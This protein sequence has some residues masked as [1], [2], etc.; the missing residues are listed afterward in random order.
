MEDNVIIKKKTN[1]FA[2]FLTVLA[3]I[4]ILFTALILLSS[5]F[6]ILYY[7]VLFCILFLT[8]F[9]FIMNKEFMDLFSKG[10]EAGKF[11]FSLYQYIPYISG[12]GAGLNLL[13]ILIIS[14]SKKTTNKTPMIVINSILIVIHII[15]FIIS[16]YLKN[17]IEIH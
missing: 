10:D 6:I 11:I 9:T 17:N 5:Y 7:V 12:I 13:S 3:F 8:L 14:L 4:A 15:V 16:I 1:K 2:V